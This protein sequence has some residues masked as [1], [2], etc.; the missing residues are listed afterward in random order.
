MVRCDWGTPSRNA[1][2]SA[3]RRYPYVGFRPRFPAGAARDGWGVLGWVGVRIWTDERSRMGGADDR[4]TKTRKAMWR[5][6]MTGDWLV[7]AHQP[8]CEAEG[9]PTGKNRSRVDLEVA[10]EGFRSRATR[11]CCVAPSKVSRSRIWSSN[12]CHRRIPLA[13]DIL[14]VETQTPRRRQ[15]PPPPLRPCRYGD[16]DVASRSFDV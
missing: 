13:E 5:M 10:Y 6:E 9:I 4:Q 8:A 11:T 12:M 16:F 14:T 1:W 15:S 3:I 7:A 2:G